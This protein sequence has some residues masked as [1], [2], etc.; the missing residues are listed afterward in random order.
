MRIMEYLNGSD[1]ELF[2]MSRALKSLPED[3]D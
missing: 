1:E 3:Q 2:V